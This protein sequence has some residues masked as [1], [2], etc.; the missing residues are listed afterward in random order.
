MVPAGPA[1]QAR[2]RGV[3]R[4]DVA[5]P[6]IDARQVVHRP[7]WTTRKRGDCN[8]TWEHHQDGQEDAHDEASAA[9]RSLDRATLGEAEAFSLALHHASIELAGRRRYKRDL[10][11]AARVGVDSLD[12][13][14]LREAVGVWMTVG[15][16]RR[17]CRPR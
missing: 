16:C 1:V 7:P 5:H 15:P 9:L 2:Q 6:Q 13:W 12:R 3:Q 8:D 4:P 17:G 10:A 14:N 11:A